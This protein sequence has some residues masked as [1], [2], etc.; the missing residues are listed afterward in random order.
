MSED[1]LQRPLVSFELPQRSRNDPTVLGLAPQPVQLLRTLR[2]KPLQG[3]HPL[4][5]QSST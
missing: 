1:S 2:D 3:P 5:M 4:G